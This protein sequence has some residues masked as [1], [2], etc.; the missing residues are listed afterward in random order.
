[1]RHMPNRFP[2]VVC[3]SP[4]V[5]RA[6]GRLQGVGRAGSSG[7]RLG[8]GHGSRRDVSGRDRFRPAGGVRRKPACRGTRSLRTCATT[9]ASPG[10]ARASRCRR[11]RRHSA[12]CCGLAR[13]TTRPMCSSTARPPAATRARTRRSRSTSPA[14]SSRAPTS[15]SFAS[16]TRRRPGSGRDPRF[17]QFNYDELPQGQAELVH[18]EWRAVAARVARRPAGALH[19]RGACLVEGVWRHRR[20]RRHR[21]RGAETRCCTESRRARCPGEPLSPVCRSP[22]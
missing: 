13:S 15:W 11:R 20:R 6:G 18:P 22:P 19:R 2:V 4:G 8:T 14:A 1:M 3:P 16:S 21:R 17:P 9:S 10:I 12:C 7:R 5:G